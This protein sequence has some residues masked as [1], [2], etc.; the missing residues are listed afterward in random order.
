M[1]EATNNTESIR[2]WLRT[3]P[4]VLSNKRFGVDYLTEKPTEYAV[5]SVPSPL[6]YRE[7][8][9]GEEVPLAVQVQNFII[10]SREPYGADLQQN[11]ENLAFYQNVT[12]WILEQN[13]ARNFPEWAGG[14]IK[15]IVP[16]ITPA[17][18]SVGSSA[19]KYQ[20]QIR[21]TYRRNE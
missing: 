8:I 13:A 10:A 3:C 21:V 1:S 17:P 11:L 7:N 12:N 6:K 4:E 14:V 20:I 16:T 19:A 15:S 18:V 9:L 5:I 2:A